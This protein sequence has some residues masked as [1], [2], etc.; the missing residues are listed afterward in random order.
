MS[1]LLATVVA[2]RGL[3]PE[4]VAT[5]ALVHLCSGSP[6][7][8][9]AMAELLRELCPGDASEA[10][11]FTGQDIDPTTEGRPDLLASDSAGT[12]LIIEAKFDAELTQAQLAGAYG[13][14]L[15]QHASAALVYLVPADRMQNLWGAVSSAHPGV[16]CE[17]ITPSEA[18]AG[19]ASTALPHEGHVLAVISWD[20]LISRLSGSLN[21]HG[22]SMG[23]A[24][25]DQ[26]AGLVKWRTRVGWSP[27]V[28]GDLAQRTGRQLRTLA[29]L[30]KAVSA[31]VSSSTTSNGSADGGP[32]RYVKTPSGKSVWFGIWF[33]WWDQYGPGPLWAKAKASTA[34]EISTLS[35]ALVAAGIRH[36]ARPAEADVLIP[37]HLPQGSE[38]A[39]AADAVRAQRKSLLDAIEATTVVVVEEDPNT[40]ESGTSSGASREDCDDLASE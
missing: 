30:V 11:V 19:L 29:D 26:I 25:L 37:V 7:T 9:S 40:S 20:S 31:E 3:Q 16:D 28:P 2:T 27:L 38:R 14:K 10:L 33:G 34:G 21:K 4:P 22:D 18:D 6:A 13:A 1:G 12:R 17:P 8:A 35:E 23:Q 5:E 39:V 24:E 36:F 32:G 15:S